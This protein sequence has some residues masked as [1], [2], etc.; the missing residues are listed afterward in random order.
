MTRLAKTEQESNTLRGFYLL[1]HAECHEPNAFCQRKIPIIICIGI[2][3]IVLVIA[4]GW[5]YY[6]CGRIIHSNRISD[7][8]YCT[9]PVFFFL[10][11]VVSG[12]PLYGYTYTIYFT[13]VVIL[14]VIVQ[15][16]HSRFE[17]AQR[18]HFATYFCTFTAEINSW[19][20]LSRYRST[21]HRRRHAALVKIV[22]FKV[23]AQRSSFGVKFPRPPIEHS[24]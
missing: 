20:E 4:L 6:L 17:L 22:K 23:P 3:A 5:C 14:T 15:M 1:H 12:G 24:K 11:A 19:Y 7:N 10:T 21:M 18:L 2:G 8:R 16:R 9:E 13:Q